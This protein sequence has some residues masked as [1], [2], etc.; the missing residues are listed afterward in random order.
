M[1]MQ[2]AKSKYDA[3]Y[4]LVRQMVLEGVMSLA[5]AKN[6]VRQRGMLTAEKMQEA[7]NE[8]HEKFW[9]TRA[10]RDKDFEE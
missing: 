9:R 1:T 3:D 5:T 2:E 7:L 10:L 4:R 6:W 8:H